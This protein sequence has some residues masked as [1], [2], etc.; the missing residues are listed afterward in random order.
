MQHLADTSHATK[1]K[2]KIQITLQSILKDDV[3]I[4]T[5]VNLRIVFCIV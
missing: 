3:V 2:W 4:V 1:N 5:D